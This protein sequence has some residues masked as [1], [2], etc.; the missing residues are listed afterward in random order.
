MEKAKENGTR[1]NKYLV[2]F[3]R[4][5]GGRLHLN[6]QYSNQ[7][8]ENAYNFCSFLNHFLTVFPLRIPGFAPCVPLSTMAQLPLHVLDPSHQRLDHLA[9]A[10]RSLFQHLYPPLSGTKFF[11][12]F[13]TFLS[14]TINTLV[15]GFQIL[16]NTKETSL[17]AFIHEL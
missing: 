9:L 17:E 16:I 7:Q 4:G 13:V 15:Q 2:G 1:L 8:Q 6:F 5:L 11:P 10:T 3:P 12:G 14:T